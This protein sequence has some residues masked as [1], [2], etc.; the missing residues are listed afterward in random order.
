MV[1]GA[2]CVVRVWRV[3]CVSC[4]VWC[5]VC[6]VLCVVCCAV[7]CGVCG[8]GVWRGLARGKLP[9]CRFKTSPCVNSK[10][11]RVYRQN[12]RLLNTCARLA[13]THEGVLN[14]HT[15]ACWT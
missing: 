15:E 12:A 9:V 8:V 2:W 14:Q 7:W 11:F 10:R 5:V 13:A 6:G 4:A 1:R 3:V